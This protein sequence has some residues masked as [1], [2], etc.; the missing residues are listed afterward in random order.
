MKS[1]TYVLSLLSLLL[2]N[3]YFTSGSRGS[4]L[5]DVF[6]EVTLKSNLENCDEAFFKIDIKNTKNDTMLVLAE[7]FL[8]QGEMDTIRKLHP[9]PGQFYTANTLYFEQLGKKFSFK[10]DAD[11]RPVFSGFP[12]LIVI[13][14]HATKT[15]YLSLSNDLC[16]IF[17]RGRFN[18]W[19]TIVY[20][21][22]NDFES[23]IDR[24]S[25]LWKNYAKSLV[26]DS[27]YKT[28]IQDALEIREESQGN[29]EITRIIWEGMPL[30]ISSPT[31]MVNRHQYR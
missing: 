15:L 17:R 10:G 7:P 2:L 18:I 6:L 27:H 29:M 5:E 25:P 9:W 13:N 12:K 24:K 30:R 31:V 4:D 8:I 3:L 19:C 16:Q 11:I 28:E 26:F 14:P 21:I 1:F 23:R 22:K 20:G